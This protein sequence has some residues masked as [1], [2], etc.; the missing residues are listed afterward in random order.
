MADTMQKNLEKYL[1]ERYTATN[2][3]AQKS[4]HGICYST[5]YIEDHT[6]EQALADIEYILKLSDQNQLELHLYSV[7]DQLHLRLFQWQEPASLSDILP[8]LE[9]FGLQ[10]L[11][12]H[13]YKLS[14]ED[15]ATIWI[16]DFTL[17]YPHAQLDLESV[18]E[19]FQQA[20]TQ[21]YNDRA[22]DDGFN[23]LVLGANLSCHEVLIFRTLAKYLQQI[24][25]RYTQTHIEKILID[26]KQIAI[27]LI[28]LFKTRHNPK[29]S[30]DLR[31]TQLQALEK[32]LKLK[33][34]S[35]VS[36]D[37]DKVLNRL[38][39]LIRASLRTNYFQ[40]SA[41]HKPYLS[42]KFESKAIPGMPLPVP[43][44]EIFVY[45]L[46]FEGIHLRNKQVARGGIRWSERHEDYRREILALMKAQVVKNTVIVPSGAKGGFVLKNLPPLAAREVI[47]K[48]VVEAYTLFISA[49]LE[50]TDNIKAGDVVHPHHVVCHD[51]PDPY[52]VVAA[53]KGTATFSDLANGLSQ[54]YGFWLG[55]AF[56]SG[57]SSGYDHKKMGIT[58]RGAWESIRR[59]FRE[60]NCD[61]DTDELS[62]VGIGDM[63]GDVFGNG[64]CYLPTLKLIAAF[65]HRHIFIDPTPDPAVSFMERERL[66]HLPTSSWEDYNPKLIS[67]GGGVFKRSL[68]SINLSLEMKR[69]L[70]VEDS[71][72][73]PNELICAILKAPV[74]LLFNGGIGTYVKSSQEADFDVGDRANEY[75]RV[76]GADLRC[77][78]VGEGGNLGFTQLGRIEYAAND[79]LI[80]TD[81]IDNSA[82]VDCSD[83][84]VNLK[85]LLGE[86]ISEG[87]LTLDERNELLASL[88][89]EIADLVLTDNRNQALVLSYSAYSSQNN[90]ALHS[91]YIKDLEAA[92]LINR[93]VEYLPSDKELLER[94]AAGLGLTRP[95]LAVLL[96]YT[97]INVKQAILK[98]ALPEDDYLKKIIDTAF[99]YSIRKNYS[100]AMKNHLLKRDIIATQLS[101]KVVNQMGITY[102][103]RM[104]RETGATVDEIVRSYTIASQVFETE[105]LQHT[106][107][108]LEYKISKEDQFE[109]LHNIRKLINLATRWFLRGNYVDESIEHVIK[110][111]TR[112]I[113][114]IEALVPD[115]MSGSA[116]NYLDSLAKKFIAAHIPDEIARRIATYRAIYSLLNIIEV[117]TTHQF[118]LVRTAKIYFAGGERMNLVWFRDEINNDTREDHWHALT[119]LT[120]RDELDTLQKALTV[121][122]MR[123]DKGEMDVYQLID[124]WVATNKRTVDR[125]DSFLSILHSNTTIEYTMF[126]IAIRELTELVKKTLRPVGA[127]GAIK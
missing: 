101:N 63:S 18:R 33:I 115:L 64:V 4:K 88:T 27:N 14:V 72:L 67:K 97:K 118:D 112:N 77:K 93:Q 106:I 110:H 99:P 32:K 80:N 30:D 109:I 13:P 2:G 89:D 8:M 114:S 34:D 10:T 38:A 26:N 51:G 15:N 40:T 41:T 36:L 75:C 70:A 125:W 94:K 102:I 22:E 62:V 121:A 56:A 44:Y 92:G 1:A 35:V 6:V 108:S 47:Q 52:L 98:S 21:V 96:A 16:N 124:N 45:A 57:G 7:E 49:L 78:V 83:H 86:D 12:E 119:R 19:L 25:F 50:L 61:I 69:V 9:H 23:K 42:I 87:I 46:S 95:E 76:N 60:L 107:D 5:G 28:E 73:T 59:H 113:Q 82:G 53:D 100:T 117:A 91:E 3:A 90:V 24:G 29:L 79:G 48:M 127:R 37:E 122:I 111:F 65:D 71:T 126:F 116:K 11:S 43:L 66:F 54:K 55:D 84:E 17:N 104:Q 68:K 31:I 39:T 123:L 58:A 20:F 85:I 103:F 120:L 74:D 105:E 81:F